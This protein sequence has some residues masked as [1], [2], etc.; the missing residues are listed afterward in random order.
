MECGERPLRA[1]FR[2]PNP[3][4]SDF[5]RASLCYCAR[6]ANKVKGDMMAGPMEPAQT[7]GPQGGAIVIATTSASFREDVIARSA[8][9]TVLVE[10]WSPRNAQSKQLAPLLQKVAE[11]AEGKIRLARMDIDA[12]P[13]IAGQLGIQ[14][15]PAVVAF[16]KGQ[17]LDGFNGLLPAG[18][19]R[20]FVERLVGPIGGEGD[21]YVA[22]G[23]ALLAAGEAEA[24]AE[25][26]T[27]ALGFDPADKRAIAGLARAQLAQGDLA[28][29]EHT[30]AQ[31]QSGDDA[32][33]PL[34]AAR[35]ALDLARQAEKV[36]DFSALERQI[37]A[38]PANHQARFD[39]AL[40]LNA[41]GQRDAAAD[42]LLAIMKRDRAWNDDAARK[43]LLQLFESWGQ[44]EPETKTARRK[45]S[46]LLY[47]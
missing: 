19:I 5:M 15:V 7:N 1:K 22:D 31:A 12:Y 30:L 41:A 47:S 16:Q 4:K 40:A 32:S 35:A 6:Q 38:D 18:Q 39:L 26:F 42:A 33:G 8:R 25:A 14:S 45:L 20:G 23:D 28:A 17:P 3:P 10:F 13:E 46:V 43:Q 44:M 29:A 24:A 11:Q 2:L 34:A 21:Q 27:E 36:G 37:E 9:Q